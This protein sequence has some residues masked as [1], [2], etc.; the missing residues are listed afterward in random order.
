[1]SLRRLGLY[2]GIA[3][4]VLWLGLI[5]IAGA[6]RPGFSHATQFISE[7][8]ERGS[9]T[10][11]MM[12]GG[13]FVF[14]GFLYL[15]F[16][17][18]LLLTLRRG[19]MITTASLLIAV[20]GIGR[21]GAGVFPCDP[22]CVGVSATQDLHK[23]FATIGFCSGILAAILWGILFRRLALFASLSWLSIGAGTVALVSLLLMSWSGNPLRVP[24]LFEHLATGV[25]SIWILVFAMRVV[26]VGDGRMP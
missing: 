13:G 15:G 9:S 3:S 2:C 25:L 1:M 18:G 12:R 6:L 10:E 20:D 24:G 5:A 21:M 11:A 19:W 14:T 17:A 26:R 7:L 8:G 4:P 16:A 22:G 23:L